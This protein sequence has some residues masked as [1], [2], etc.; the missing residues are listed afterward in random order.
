MMT[1]A[2]DYVDVPND[3][4]VPTTPIDPTTLHELEP[5]AVTG[6]EDLDEHIARAGSAVRGWAADGRRRSSL[7]LAWAEALR[8]EAGLIAVD[9]VR[10]TGKPI[11]EAH[12]EVAGAIDALEYNAGMCRLSD[13]AS[14][15]LPDETISRLVREPLGVTTLLVPWNWP[16]ML[17]FRDLAPAL[18]AGVTVVVKP[19]P[20]TTHITARVI[21]IGRRVGITDNIVALA[22]GDIAVAQ[23]LI[24]HPDVRGVAFTGSTRVGGAVLTAAAKNMTRPLLELGGKNPAV[25][26]PDADLDVVL[27]LLA[28]SVTIT[29]G[30]MC[31]ACSRILVHRSLHK[32]VRDA[33]TSTLA[34][35]RTGDPTDPTTELGPLISPAHAASVLEHVD[36]ARTHADVTGGAL[37]HPG[38][39]GHVVTPAVVETPAA[40]SAI[41]TTDVFGPVVTIELYDDTDEVVRLANATSYGLVAGVFGRDSAAAQRLAVG[42]QAGTVWVNGWGGTYPEVPAGGYKCSGLGRT[43]GLAGIWQ[44]TELKHIHIS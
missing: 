31:M 14:T 33:I 5:V 35:L 25:I 10:E 2:P 6:P 1:V 16:V 34:S 7:M 12:R 37:A 18:A 20:Q 36:Q 42:I 4:D 27:P 9:V 28:R 3:W 30:Q 41:V 23:H 24:R 13:G 8:A 40:D 44:F 32:Q 39:A 22:Q 21:Q 19:S 29:A 38:I 11:G 15:T 17:L 26:L 43:R